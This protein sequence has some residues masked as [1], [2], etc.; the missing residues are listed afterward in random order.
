MLG[1]CCSFVGTKSETSVHEAAKD[2]LVETVQ[3]LL[4]E[5]AN[6]EDLD[7]EGLTPL[8]VAVKYKSLDVARLLVNGGARVDVKDSF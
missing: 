1:F 6:L 4:K 7:S 5:G 3:L 8:H 2:N